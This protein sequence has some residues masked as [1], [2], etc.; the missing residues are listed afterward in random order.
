MP[1]YE[2]EL[3]T[4]EKFAKR[5]NVGRTTVFEWIKQGKLLSGRHFIKLGRVIRFLWGP[6][7]LEKL[8]ED[9]NPVGLL[10]PATVAVINWFANHP[11][12]I[13]LLALPPLRAPTYH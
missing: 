11:N 6:E 10:C 12:K 5:M 3:I 4:L 9:S 1:Q 2:P 8:H 7:L 13:G